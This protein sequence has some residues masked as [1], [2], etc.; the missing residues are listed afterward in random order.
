MAKQQA[1]TEATYDSDQIKVLKGLEPVR[2]RPGMY[3][4]DT[5]DGTGLHHMVQEV[6][7]NSVD[8]A[9]EGHCDEVDII[10]H[11]DG[12]CTVKD[13]GR[14][15]PVSN[16]PTEKVPTPVVVMTTLHAGGKFD[17]DS[18]K[19]SGGLHG[20]GVSC[21]NALSSKLDLKICRD[22]HIHTM[23]FS[24]GRV[25]KALER[26]ARTKATGTEVTFWPDHD[27]FEIVTRFSFDTLARRL[28]ELAFLN[29]NLRI[30]LVDEREEPVRR[31]SFHY[32]GGLREFVSQRAEGHKEYQAI[33]EKM[34]YCM[35]ELDGVVVE[36]ALQWGSGYVESH[37][38][39]T[40]NIPQRDGGTHQ[41]G[42]RAALTRVIKS[43][44]TEAAK[45]SKSRKAPVEI[46]GEDI[47]EGLLSVLAV[48]VPDPKFSSQTKDKL[49]SSEVRPI[50]EELFA[51]ELGI[52]LQERPRDAQAI[53]S[54]ISAAASARH[55]ARQA[56][57]NARRK[58]AFDSGGLPGKLADCQEKDPSRSEIYLVEGDSAGGSAKQGR[59]RSFQAILPLRGKILNVEKS[60]LDKMIKSKVIQDLILALGV[61]LVHDR[62]DD[63]ELKSEEEEASGELLPKALQQLRYHR[64]IIMTDADVDGSHIETLL[65]TFF[66]RRLRELIDHGCIYLALPPLYK[67]RIGKTEQY[68]Q[69]DL[70]LEKFLIEQALKG[71]S[72]TPTN[73]KK[74]VKEFPAYFRKLREAEAIIDRHTAGSKPVDEM[75][76]RALLHIPDVLTLD[77]EANAKKAAS[78]LERIAGKDLSIEPVKVVEH[79]ELD[80]HRRIYGTRRHIGRLTPEFL[81]TRDYEALCDIAGLRQ[82][83]NE[84]GTIAHGSEALIVRDGADAAEWLMNK[85]RA[86]VTVQ[87]YKGLG[88][89]NPQQLWETT[90]DPSVRRLLRVKVKDA[91]DASDLFADLMGEDVKPRKEFIEKGALQAEISL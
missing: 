90:M 83:F 71:V 78:A 86:A 46:S 40:N 75:I 29:S 31:Q 87:H 3:I 1:K 50:V 17:D 25:S 88:E 76:L 72:F 54:K 33:H 6:V 12:S 62:Q 84:E 68:L 41:T 21:V 26:G 77:S 69:D 10:L 60:G 73:A 32:A 79:Y 11:D 30:N 35:K 27:I 34:F 20:V 47:R 19:V 7:D 67:A 39:Y 70:E 8:E 23:S 52:F 58:S 51:E 36:I 66:F 55:A 22:G 82:M 14:G 80:C 74:P 91:Q 38:C 15:I 89:M 43:Y 9:L 61:Q 48:K 65:L 63:D 53:C 57:E 5:S 18:Y 49:V 37:R 81:E 45:Q 59:D 44:M 13:N 24:K 64:V 4:G 56:R 16:H 28:Q 85:V 42:F 2:K